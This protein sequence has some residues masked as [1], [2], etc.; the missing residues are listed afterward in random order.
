MW[1]CRRLGIVRVFNG[2]KRGSRRGPVN[3]SF[4]LY[5]WS[6]P[7]LYS[8]PCDW[9]DN[10]ANSGIHDPALGRPGN[11]GEHW[12]YIGNIFD[13]LPYAALAGSTR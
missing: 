5:H 3:N 4:H 9:R 2:H 12:E 13:V 7:S 1:L 10:D 6:K 11:G 8:H